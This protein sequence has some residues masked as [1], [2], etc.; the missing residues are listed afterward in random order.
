MDACKSAITHL[1]QYTVLEI[2]SVKCTTFTVQYTK[3]S[4]ISTATAVVN[5]KTNQLKMLLNVF[6]TTYTY[7][8]WKIT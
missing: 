4:S 5:L 1:I 3:V 2:W 8:N 7:S 6:S